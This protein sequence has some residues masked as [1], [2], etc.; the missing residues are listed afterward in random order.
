MRKV[1]FYGLTILLVQ[2]KARNN[3][4]FDAIIKESANAKL[5]R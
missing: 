4:D 2:K 1:R 3:M 5:C